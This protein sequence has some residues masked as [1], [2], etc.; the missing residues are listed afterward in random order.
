[1]TAQSPQPAWHPA[2]PVARSAEAPPT[3]VQAV[4]PPRTASTERHSSTGDG[5]ARSAARSRTRHARSELASANAELGAG[6]VRPP[7]LVSMPPVHYPVVVQR[8][9]ISGLLSKLLR[10]PIAGHRVQVA[11]L[12]NRSGH[13]TTP[14]L[15]GG[16]SSPSGFDRAALQA[17]MAARFRPATSNGV[18]VKAWAQ[19]TFELAR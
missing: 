15:R 3:G 18:P 8:H 19:L 14:E 16:G 7:V 12:V 4:P 10:R 2:A 5:T 1:M 13:V 11:V 17:A 9:R 6:P